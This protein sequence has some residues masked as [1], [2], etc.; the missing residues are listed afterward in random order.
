MHILNIPWKV[1][2]SVENTLTIFIDR[3][4]S[5]E[6][7]QMLISQLIQIHYAEVGSVGGCTMP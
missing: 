6:A 4:S 5:M 3:R 2:S 1:K 7:D